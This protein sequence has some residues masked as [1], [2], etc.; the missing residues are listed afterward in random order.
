MELHCMQGQLMDSEGPDY[1]I[2]TQAY[3]YVVSVLANL[4]FKSPRNFFKLAD[5]TA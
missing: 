4:K 2:D 5:L 3:R 1:L